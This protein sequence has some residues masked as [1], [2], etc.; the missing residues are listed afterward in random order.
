M[1]LSY[2]KVMTTN[3]DFNFVITDYDCFNVNKNI[4]KWRISQ[5][6][7]V[8]LMKKENEVTDM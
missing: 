4:N 3:F 6:S 5:L 1:I 7:W 8:G 2:D